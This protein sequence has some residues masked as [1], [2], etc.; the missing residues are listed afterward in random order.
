MFGVICL[1]F[2]RKYLIAK[3]LSSLFIAFVFEFEGFAKTA[4]TNQ[5]VVRPTLTQSGNAWGSKSIYFLIF[6]AVKLLW[7]NKRGLCPSGQ[8]CDC[9]CENAACPNVI[10]TIWFIHSRDFPAISP[11]VS[12]FGFSFCPF[13][14]S[15]I[16]VSTDL[17]V[18][19]VLMGAYDWMVWNVQPWRWKSI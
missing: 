13:P 2:Q 1:F 19:Q 10:S 3:L 14:P 12:A 11:P 5:C 8:Q 18:W 17:S 6:C 7:P 9:C 15:V 4:E 16:S